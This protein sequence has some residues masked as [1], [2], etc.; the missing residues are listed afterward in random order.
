MEATHAVAHV[1]A[2]EYRAIARHVANDGVPSPSCSGENSRVGQAIGD[3]TYAAMTRG[4][5]LAE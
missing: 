4:L 1:T 2:D 5:S 3:L